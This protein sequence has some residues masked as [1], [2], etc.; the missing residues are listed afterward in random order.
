M[1]DIK[2]S[3]NNLIVGLGNPGREYQWTRHN[4]GFLVLEKLSETFG[5]KFKKSSLTNGVEALVKSQDRH[6]YLFM[7]QT[8]MNLS[9][10][11]VQR[12]LEKREID[13]KNLLVVCDDISIPFGTKRLRSKG[14]SGGHNGLKSII[15]HLTSDQFARLRLGVGQPG[16]NMADYVLDEFSRTEKKQL[17][18]F[19]DE[20][21]ESCLIWL[22]GGINKAMEQTNRRKEN[23][24]E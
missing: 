22:D 13:L 15:H 3:E 6:V 18:Q 5:S 17:P 1:S 2:L 7:P 8:Y 14:S 21:K 24:K 19:I 9:G 12:V 16:G 10:T 23:G 20:A 4:L 11:A